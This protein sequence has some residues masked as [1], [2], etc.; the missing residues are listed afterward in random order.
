MHMRDVALL[1]FFGFFNC[2]ALV[3]DTPHGQFACPRGGSA[4][5]V[6]DISA[7]NQLL[8][9]TTKEWFAIT[10]KKLEQLIQTG[11]KKYLQALTAI[12]QSPGYWFQAFEA[13]PHFPTLQQGNI[14]NVA[15]VMPPPEDLAILQAAGE[16]IVTHDT[17][18]TT[19]QNNKIPTCGV[20]TK[21]GYSQLICL[22]NNVWLFFDSHQQSNNSSGASLY[23]F[24]NTSDFQ[25]F[26]H[27]YHAFQIGYSTD[28]YNQANVTLFTLASP[29]SAQV[30]LSAS[31]IRIKKRIAQLNKQLTAQKNMIKNLI[32]GITKNK[33][34]LK[35]IESQ[36]NRL[37]K[38]KAQNAS[39]KTK[40]MIRETNK[41][42]QATRK[43]IAA[44]KKQLKTARSKQKQ[45]EGKLKKQRALLKK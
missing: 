37:A 33:K 26:L 40:K 22:K 7:A 8:Q 9:M 36:R 18:I 44:Q 4:C 24:K 27:T 3:V 20:W 6:I 34:A 17:L 31:A 32:A 42:L 45:L 35:K 15:R 12:Y 38:T 11:V 23:L 21:R 25:Q 39:H 2:N 13:A 16:Y 1:I 28:L 29:T 19:I 5:T 10:P 41:K 14:L 43:T 30:K